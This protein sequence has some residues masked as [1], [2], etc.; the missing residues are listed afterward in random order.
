MKK[1][2]KVKKICKVTVLIL[3]EESFAIRVRRIRKFT[4]LIYG[5]LFRDFYNLFEI[6]ALNNRCVLNRPIKAKMRHIF[7][8]IKHSGSSFSSCLSEVFLAL[9][10]CKHTVNAS[11]CTL[12]FLAPAAHLFVPSRCPPT[13]SFF[14]FQLFFP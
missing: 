13:P 3:I 10:Y 6:M 5:R 2:G 11:P 1:L 9:Q 7:R 12:T 4:L 14:Y 8:I